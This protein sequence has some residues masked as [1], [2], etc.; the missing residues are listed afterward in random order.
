[1]LATHATHTTMVWL[2]RIATVG[3][4]FFLIKGLAWLGVIAAVA[5]WSL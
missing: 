4:L 3:F 1:M 5:I 2:K